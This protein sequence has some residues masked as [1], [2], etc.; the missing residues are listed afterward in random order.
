MTYAKKRELVQA[1]NPEG[2]HNY[3]PPYENDAFLKYFLSTVKQS[4][5]FF[6]HAC[7]H[8]IN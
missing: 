7:T 6:T 1:L 4:H 2:L 8:A 5:E 3:W